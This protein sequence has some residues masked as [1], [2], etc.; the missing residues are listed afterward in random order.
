[1]TRKITSA[2]GSN[3]TRCSCIGQFGGIR[4]LSYVSSDSKLFLTALKATWKSRC[5][6]NVIFPERVR[7]SWIQSDFV[8]R[9]RHHWYVEEI[10]IPTLSIQKCRTPPGNL[11]P[12]PLKFST[13]GGLNR[14]CQLHTPARDFS[15][16]GS[17]VCRR[18]NL[19]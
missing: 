18:E 6:L 16:N 1:M 3:I 11:L 19:Y 5:V 7:L 17:D 13:Y 14:P 15:A 9:R 8:I 12:N 4:A 10:V 2:T